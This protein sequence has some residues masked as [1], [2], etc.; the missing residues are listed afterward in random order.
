MNQGRQ[1]VLSQTWF[2]ADQYRLSQLILG[3]IVDAVAQSPG[4]AAVSDHITA[5][6]AQHEW[7]QL[8]QLCVPISQ[9][10]L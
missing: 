5:H 8:Q 1:I 10:L 4:I 3:G 2:S 6:P 9:G 7:S